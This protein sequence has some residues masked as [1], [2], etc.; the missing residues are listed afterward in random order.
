MKK[1]LI[2]LFVFLSSAL[3]YAQNDVVGLGAGT[4]SCKSFI[5]LVKS[6]KGLEKESTMLMFDSWMTGYVSGRNAQLNALNYD[7]VD[8][9]KSRNLGNKL[10]QVCETEI[11][12]GNGKILIMIVAMRMFDEMYGVEIKQRK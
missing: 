7:Y 12:N 11:K 3:A 6:G 4:T 2:T 10:T 8:L 5:D 1:I 9:G